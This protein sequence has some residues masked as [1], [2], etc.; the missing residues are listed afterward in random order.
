[1]RPPA[2]KARGSKKGVFY[3]ISNEDEVDEE[4]RDVFAPPE[5]QQAEELESSLAGDRT[6]QSLGHLASC[7]PLPETQ[8]L[9]PAL[10]MLL[11][12]VTNTCDSILASKEA[13]KATQL[14][15]AFEGHNNFV[16]K[17]FSITAKDSLE[18]LAIRCVT[19]NQNVALSDFCYEM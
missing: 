6:L 19:A 5:A 12:I 7:A 1:M 13:N 15:E 10:K 4:D 16:V 14:I 2:R 3:H 17:V 8:V 9:P 18:S 11:L